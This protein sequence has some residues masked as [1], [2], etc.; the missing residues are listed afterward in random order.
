MVGVQIKVEKRDFCPAFTFGNFY[1]DIAFFF[2]TILVLITSGR[3]SS[4]LTLKRIVL[5]DIDPLK[6]REMESAMLRTLDAQ[7]EPMQS[8]LLQ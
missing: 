7:S 5:V 2:H 6:A 1:T 8:C 4:S 3:S